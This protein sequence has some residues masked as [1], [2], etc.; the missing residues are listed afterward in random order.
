MSILVS[1]VTHRFNPK[2]LRQGAY[3]T[4]NFQ[5]IPLRQNLLYFSIIQIWL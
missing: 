5:I 2:K 1:M 4:V 3:K